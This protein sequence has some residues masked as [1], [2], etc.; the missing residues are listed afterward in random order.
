MGRIELQ[1]LVLNIMFDLID[2]FLFSDWLLADDWFPRTYHNSMQYSCKLIY[3]FVRCIRTLI[4]LSFRVHIKRLD[5][6]LIRARVAKFNKSSNLNSI[7]IFKSDFVQ[8][9][10][11]RNDLSDVILSS[12]LQIFVYFIMA[13]I[14]ALVGSTLDLY[15][16]A[17]RW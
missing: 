14:C 5:G 16:F 8:S 9:G 4:I 11:M 6:E 15:V 13:F 12:V 1:K 10:L 3:W 2:Y 17:K 7:N